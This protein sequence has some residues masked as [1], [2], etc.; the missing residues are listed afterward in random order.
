MEKR[1]N[2]TG[3]AGT[4]G[5]VIRSQINLDQGAGSLYC[6]QVLEQQAQNLELSE[7]LTGKA[8]RMPERQIRKKS[9]RRTHLLRDFPGKAD[10]YG[11]HALSFNGAL[12]QPHG[13]VAKPSGRG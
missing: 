12:D 7:S 11:G 6:L 1:L 10:G 13:L 5:I 8:Q 4:G 3:R 9:A 2:L